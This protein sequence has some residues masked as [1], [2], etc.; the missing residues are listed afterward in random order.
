MP[1]TYETYPKPS[2]DMTKSTKS[3]PPSGTGGN[4]KSTEGAMGHIKTTNGEGSGSKK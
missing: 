3:S 1:P 4:P 2:A